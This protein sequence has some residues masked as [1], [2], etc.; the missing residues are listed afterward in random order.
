MPGI[1][2]P[3]ARGPYDDTEM[4]PIIRGHR[5]YKPKKSSSKTSRE[6]DDIEKKESEIKAGLSAVE[7]RD[8]DIRENEI[9]TIKSVESQGVR[10]SNRSQDGVATQRGESIGQNNTITETPEKNTEQALYMISNTSLASSRTSP[11]KVVDSS[12]TSPAQV[13]DRSRT[14]PAKVVDKDLPVT[15][16]STS[17]EKVFPTPV[18]KAAINNASTWVRTSQPQDNVKITSPVQIAGG[19]KVAVLSTTN[20]AFLDFTDNWLESMRRVGPLPFTIIV[21]EDEAT[22]AHLVNVSDVNVIRADHLSASKK[23]VFDTPEYKKFVNKRPQY[24]LDLL[25]KG[26]DVLFS[27][28]DTVWLQNPFPYFADDYYDVFGQLDLYNPKLKFPRVLCAGFVYYKSSDKTIQLVQTW[29]HNMRRYGD[30]KPDQLVLNNIINRRLVAKLKVSNLD[31][32]RFLSGHY[33]FDDEWRQ[34]HPGVNPVMIHNNWIVGHDAKVERFKRLGMWYIGYSMTERPLTID[35]KKDPQ[36]I[37]E[38]KVSAVNETSVRS[39]L[40]SPKKE[41]TISAKRTP[42][43]VPKVTLRAVQSEGNPTNGVSLDLKPGVAVSV[44]NKSAIMTLESGSKESAANGAQLTKYNMKSTNGTVAM[45]P[46]LESKMDLI[47]NN[48]ANKVGISSRS[49]VT[50]VANSIKAGPPQLKPVDSVMSKSVKDN[51]GLYRM[52]DET[53][54]KGT[55]TKS[56]LSLS[57]NS[58]SKNNSTRT[59]ILKSELQSASISLVTNSSVNIRKPP[60]N[61]VEGHDLSFNVSGNHER[62]NKSLNNTSSPNLKVKSGNA[63]PGDLAVSNQGQTIDKTIVSKRQ[64][65]PSPTKRKVAVLSTTNAA[66]LDF[67]DNWLE[68]MRRV[69]PLPFTI[70]VAEDEAT[71]A[72][73]VNVSDVTVIRADHLSASKKLVFDTPEY[74]KFVNKRPQYILDL[75]RKGYDVLFSDVDTVWLQNPF[76]YF[77]SDRYDVFGQVDMYNPKLKF[78]RVLCAGFVYYKANDKT[79]QLVQTWIHNMRRYGDRKPDQVVLNNVIN[80]RLVGRLKVN[81]LDSNKFLSGHY[82]FDDEWRQNHPDVKPVMLHNNWIVG[83]DAKVDRFKRLGMW[84]ID[85]SMTEKPK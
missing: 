39:T 43:E 41:D 9:K 64:A 53:H 10:E 46:K 74:K 50:L 33:Y 68:S 21:A 31:P 54:V 62:E 84:Y 3:R 52:V 57:V 12:R 55:N 29:I 60:T 85:Y 2:A 56:N 15:N 27:D 17:S 58:P 20:A 44:S 38:S 35:V 5:R 79:I 81:N 77:E 82:Y 1:E 14:S 36:L 49:N 34:T 47:N 22:Y 76:P 18:L 26:Y 11:V 16:S 72:H 19:K 6:R 75:L 42:S 61:K 59:F 8:D 70:I 63:V 28:V 32:N 71:Y 65:A 48:S 73:L 37:S 7:S 67:T 45:T 66:F 30:R 23:L 25:K 13:V 83:H 69:G 78:P 40:E 24:I 80:R 51:S 4:Q